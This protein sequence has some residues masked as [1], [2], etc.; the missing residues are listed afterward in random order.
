[1]RAALTLGAV[2]LLGALLVVGSR[3][4]QRQAPA[5]TEA[6]A[7]PSPRA[8]TAGPSPTTP[9]L[10]PIGVAGKSD[11]EPPSG[12]LYGRI[13]TVDGTTFEGRIRL[14]GNQ[15]AFWSDY[16]LGTKRQN[17]WAEQVPAERRPQRRDRV[18]FLGFDLGYRE[19]PLNLQRYFMTRFGDLARIE[20]QGRDV[21]VTLKS[22]SVFELDRLEA[23]DF[24][25]GLRVWDTT[26]GVVDL[27]SLRVRTIE[28]LP[29]APLDDL[30]GRLYGTVQTTQG[31]FTGFLQWD[32]EANLGSDELGV[33]DGGAALR[34]DT[35]QTITRRAPEGAAVLL[36]DGRELPYALDSGNFRGVS[37][38]DPRYGRVLVQWSA[39]ERLELGVPGAAGSGPAY[40]DFAPGRPLR[41][42]VTTKDGRRL[43]GRLVFDLD[44]SETTETLDAP[45]QGVN[46]TLPFDLVAALEPS[47]RVTLRSGEELQLER[48]GD[49][50]EGNAG[51]L[52]FADEAQ[53]PEYV[54]WA[55]VA[56]VD[57]T[58]ASP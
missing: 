26:R 41:G 27:D 16:F 2:A 54:P 6:P 3:A 12:F 53:A 49:L 30:P 33:T 13:T 5:I 48:S 39:F 11:A 45:A 1:M 9:V 46:Y 50:G 35:V 21:R 28:L 37:V 19:K 20:S 38:D 22:G 18:S 4:C 57:L 29:T 14:G 25:D 51:L 47:G 31:A 8:A 24:D 56:R 23:S 32:R 34:F 15:E 42:A 36:R 44:E 40:G 52:V 7:I 17:P 43:A 58:P 55:D 10:P